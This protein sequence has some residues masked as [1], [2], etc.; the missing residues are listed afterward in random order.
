[1][2][3]LKRYNESKNYTKELY[4]N[5][6]VENFGFSSSDVQDWIQDI[7]DEHPN[8]DF[9]VYSYNENCFI[10]SLFYKDVSNLINRKTVP[11]STDSIKFLNDRLKEHGCYLSYSAV[12][13]V[14]TRHFDLNKLVT[15]SDKIYF[16]AFKLDK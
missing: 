10:I 15:Y 8:L 5:F 14:P 9:L 12:G 2:K 3:Y 1:V 13:Y 16:M 7:L 11:I 4:E 6:L